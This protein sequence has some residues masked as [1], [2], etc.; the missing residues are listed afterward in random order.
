MVTMS[1]VGLPADRDLLGT[2]TEVNDAC[3][4]VVADVVA[5]GRVAVGDDVV[6]VD[7]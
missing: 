4:G 3:L 1:Q 2:V 7:A 6:L 5:V